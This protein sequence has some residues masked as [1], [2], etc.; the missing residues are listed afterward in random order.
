MTAAQP[1]YSD[2][3]PGY[4]WGMECLKDKWRFDSFEDNDAKFGRC[5]DE[6]LTCTEYEPR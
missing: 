6:A 2:M 1:D 4:N 3:T 5:L